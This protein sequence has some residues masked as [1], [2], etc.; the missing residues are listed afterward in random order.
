MPARLEPPICGVSTNLHAISR[1]SGGASLGQRPS[2]DMTRYRQPLNSGRG[3]WE[4]TRQSRGRPD[5]PIRSLREPGDAELFETNLD[6]TTLSPWAR[7]RR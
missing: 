7:Q 6:P 3:A 4:W 2:A 1:P 5:N